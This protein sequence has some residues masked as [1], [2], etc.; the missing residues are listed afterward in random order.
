M[1]RWLAEMTFKR[2]FD[3][4]V[5]TLGLLV[6]LPFFPFIALAI[7]LDSRGPVFFYQERAG[8]HGKPFKVIKFR[9]MVVDAEKKL[10]DL[11]DTDSLNEPV[12]K[13]R[14]DPRIT[15]VGKILRRWSIDEI[16][17]FINIFRGEMSLVGPRPEEIWLVNRYDG[18]QRQ[19]LA[20]KPGLTG[21]MQIAGRGELDFS[22]RLKLELEYIQDYSFKRDLEIV[23]KS[24]PAVI[25]GKGAF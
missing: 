2:F 13:I 12:F 5:S 9:S 22:T 15:R 25:T 11:I 3:I 19:R 23:L 21:P 4:L 24:I 8:R 18:T 16:P 6:V 7:I 14:H 20:V 1:L 17:Q 10:G